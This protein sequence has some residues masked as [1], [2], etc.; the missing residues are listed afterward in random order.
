MYVETPEFSTDTDTSD[1]DE[2]I[3]E[4]TF[5]I[6]VKTFLLQ[7]DNR[8]LPTVQKKYSPAKVS[9]SQETVLNANDIYNIL[10]S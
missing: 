7:K 9:I 3:H 6:E 4:A 2:K 1:E 10:A 5:S 8:D